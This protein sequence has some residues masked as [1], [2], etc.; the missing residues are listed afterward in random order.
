MAGPRYSDRREF[1]RPHNVPTACA[2]QSESD[3]IQTCDLSAC[4]GE[5]CPAFHTGAVYHRAKIGL[6]YTMTTTDSSPINGDNWDFKIK[7]TPEAEEIDYRR[8]LL[9][10]QVSS[11]LGLSKLGTP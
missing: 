6:R 10:R 9:R 11:L 4:Q 3:T 8:G 1:H 2:C 7:H 5:E